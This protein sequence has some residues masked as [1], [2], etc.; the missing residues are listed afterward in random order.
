MSG[1]WLADTEFVEE[2]CG[3]VCESGAK[4][5]FEITE[6]SVIRDPDTAIGHLRRFAEIGIPIAID[7]YG[8]GLSSL[9][10]LKQ[11][12]ARELKIDQMFVLP[13]PSRHR[14]PLHVRSPIA[15]A[16]PLD[17]EQQP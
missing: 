3:L 17:M 5:G 6:T 1:Q 9:A 12:P 10:Y 13:L 14:D 16:H 8:A 4:I 15:L 7:D 2:A 11:L